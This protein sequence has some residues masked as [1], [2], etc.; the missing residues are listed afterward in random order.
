[1]RGASA[2]RRG[3]QLG[4]RRGARRGGGGGGRRRRRR[5]RRGHAAVS[6][7]ESVVGGLLQQQLGAAMQAMTLASVPSRRSSRHSSRRPCSGS[8]KVA[9]GYL[10]PDEA[11]TSVLCP[12]PRRVDATPPAA[13]RFSPR[14]S[15]G[16]GVCLLRWRG[17]PHSRAP[18]ARSSPRSL[19]SP[20]RTQCPAPRH[21]PPRRAPR[22]DAARPR[23]T[24]T[25]R[26]A[27]PRRPRCRRRRARRRVGELCATLRAA[28]G[29]D[30]RL[31]GRERNSCAGAARERGARHLRLRARRR[32]RRD[33]APR[34]R[35][36]RR[37]RGAAPPRRRLPPPRLRA[38]G[39]SP[40]PLLKTFRDVALPSSP[41]SPPPTPPPSRRRPPRW[42]TCRA[43][44]PPPAAP[45]AAGARR[46]RTTRRRRSYR[47]LKSLL[48]LA[49]Q[50]ATATM[51]PTTAPPGSDG[52]HE[53]VVGRA[54]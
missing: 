35:C 46:Q 48:E 2:R 17:D 26:G 40:V 8:C 42:R 51:A 54:S 33:A 13:P 44:R 38:A 1:M 30:R 29:G 34:R 45:P 22:L 12:P 24:A 49:G 20:P 14:A 27:L 43:R 5:R 53:E 21:P 47:Q 7:V 10:M 23:T 32:A 41:S 36:L 25:L 52:A 6:L 15:G 50:L 31:C 18:H 16:G 39:R 9:A 28:G 3:R 11:S 4:C 19:V 37:C